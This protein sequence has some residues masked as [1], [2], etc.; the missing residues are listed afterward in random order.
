MCD[1]GWKCG[2]E[3]CV[4]R[5]GL[6]PTCINHVRHQGT[7]GYHGAAFDIT[8]CIIVRTKVADRFI[9]CGISRV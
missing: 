4:G 6:Y 8:P 9:L 2:L 1:C 3:G 5:R 7:Y